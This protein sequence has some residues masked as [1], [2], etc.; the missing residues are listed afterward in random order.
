MVAVENIGDRRDVLLWRLD[1]QHRR[2]ALEAAVVD[3]RV[4]LGLAAEQVRPEAGRPG[5]GAG[6]GGHAT[7][8]AI[9]GVQAYR[10]VGDVG[11]PQVGCSRLC[12]SL[13]VIHGHHGL[14]RHSNSPLA[15]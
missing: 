12:M 3:G 9:L 7:V 5:V 1:G 8:R 10:A 6:R 14:I 11:C 4:M 2:A 13:R 15:G